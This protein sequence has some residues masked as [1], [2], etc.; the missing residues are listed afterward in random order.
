MIWTITQN[1]D[2]LFPVLLYFELAGNEII[3]KLFYWSP[4][5]GALYFV[6]NVAYYTSIKIILFVLILAIDCITITFALSCVLTKKCRHMREGVERMAG[7]TLREISNI[8]L[9]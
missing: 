8:F 2:K 3:S 5:D 4:I 9:S 1:C 7:I 6:G